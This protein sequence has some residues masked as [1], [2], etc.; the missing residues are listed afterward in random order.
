MSSPELNAGLEHQGPRFEWGPPSGVS[1]QALVD[2]GET[3]GQSRTV[4]I[5]AEKA[6]SMKAWH[7][8][9]SSP[10]LPAGRDLLLQYQRN[11]IFF[12]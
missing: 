1:V 10:E 4:D 12:S 9:C 8:V 5:D 2:P 6:Y 11:A 7:P 3:T